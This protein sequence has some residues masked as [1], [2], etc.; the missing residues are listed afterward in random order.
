VPLLFLLVFFTK[1]V[2]TQSFR[3]KRLDPI[4]KTRIALHSAPIV[5][6]FCIFSI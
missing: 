1:W 4:Y 3:I 6:T 5:N 2:L